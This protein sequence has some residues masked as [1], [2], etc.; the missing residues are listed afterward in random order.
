MSGSGNTPLDSASNDA[1]QNMSP[2]P[3]SPAQSCGSAPDP[4]AETTVSPEKKW[5]IAMALF[6]AETKSVAGAD[7]KIDLPDG[8]AVEG[9]VLS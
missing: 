6:D 9:L 7:Y 5:W 1:N 8:T 4:A 3:G 2:A